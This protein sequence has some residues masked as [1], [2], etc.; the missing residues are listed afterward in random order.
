M[1]GEDPDR[2]GPL[3]QRFVFCTECNGDLQDF[4]FSE[5]ADDLEAL[6]KTQ[7]R[8]KKSGR[9]VGELCSKLFIADPHYSDLYGMP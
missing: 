9:F 3:K 7:A 1:L 6:K 5:S 8:C 4:C 2:L